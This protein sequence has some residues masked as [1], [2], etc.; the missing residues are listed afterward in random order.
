MRRLRTP[1]SPEKS[2]GRFAF[3]T[4]GETTMDE[5]EHIKII[6]DFL[7]DKPFVSPRIRSALNITVHENKKFR[8]ALE[9][10][11]NYSFGDPVEKLHIIKIFALQTLNGV[12]T[13]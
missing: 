12:K 6:Q 2:G 8:I 4:K 7:D 3:I 10:I 11:S 1:R 9:V 5:N 13:D